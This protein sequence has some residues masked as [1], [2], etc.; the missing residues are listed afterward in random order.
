MTY[1]ITQGCCNDG[2]CIAVCPVQCIR[3]R[4]GDPDYTTAEQL[5]IDP[6]SCIDCGACLAECPVSAVEADYS[7]PDELS[8]YL[9]INAEYFIDHPITDTLP[10]SETRR[11]LPVERP[12]LRVAV[13]GSG[14]AACYLVDEISQIKGA[15][16]SVFERLPVPFGLARA[17]VAPDH[18]ATKAI[19][20]RFRTVLSRA[21]VSCYFNVEVSRDVTVDELLGYHHAVV[22]AAGASSDRKLGIPGENLPGSFAAREF[23]GWY[24]GHPDHAADEF[25]IAGERV[26]VIGNGNVA[27]DVARALAR[28]VDVFA[29]TDMA[30]HALE[31]LGD[32]NV[33]EVVVVARRSPANAAYTTGELM[34]LARLEGVDLLA[35]ENELSDSEGTSTWRHNVLS[36][37]AE[38]EPTPGN[39]RV[40]LRF[41]LT[42]ERIDDNGEGCVGGITFRHVDGTEESFETPLVLRAAGYRGAPFGN[43]PFD[44]TSGTLAQLEGRVVDPS[45]GEP[46]TGLYCTGWIKRGPSGGIGTNKTDSAETAAVLFDDFVS[47]RLVDPEQDAESLA[48]WVAERQPDMID[49]AAWQRIDAAERARGRA[50]SRPRSAF[51]SVEDMLAASRADA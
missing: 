32:S 6:V 14:P 11:R 22:V 44:E 38:R 41:G 47:G 36:A 34:A 4:P 51:V 30:D 21:N 37:A 48:G 17:G 10:A 2:A 16:V 15:E 9:Q 3:P 8:D 20:D 35:V 1:V 43:L 39:R 12:S 28:P 27:L 31:A 26:V 29:T 42:P 7:L 25:D 5:Y 33:Q 49:K 18:P 19:S 24:N 23:V 46:M 40:V 45:S 13:V 50:A